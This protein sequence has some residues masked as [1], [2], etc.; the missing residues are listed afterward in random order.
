M[1]CKYAATVRLYSKSSNGYCAQI[2]LGEC[3]GVGVC[4]CRCMHA[5]GTLNCSIADVFSLMWDSGELPG[6]TL[7]Y[8][9]MSSGKPEA[10]H[11]FYCAHP[12]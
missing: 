1:C 12:E 4:G 5:S 6:K 7:P 3:V 9:A 10:L 11:Y 2:K 8:E